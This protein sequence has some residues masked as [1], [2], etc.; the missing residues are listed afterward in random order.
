MTKLRFFLASTLAVAALL[1][2]R[3]SLARERT[4]ADARVEGS[5]P[6]CVIDDDCLEAHLVCDDTSKQCVVGCRGTR[7]CPELLAVCSSTD[8]TIG[9]CSNASRESLTP[10]AYPSAA[11]AQRASMSGPYGGSCHESSAGG[12]PRNERGNECI[13]CAVSGHSVGGSTSSS[14]AAVLV[15]ALVLASLRRRSCAA[16]ARAGG[17]PDAAARVDGRRRARRESAR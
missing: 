5:S 10:G 1:T 15:G 6:G 9:K 8:A 11:P 3:P 17:E 7:A 2:G 14:F 13:S 4:A 16:S 12:A